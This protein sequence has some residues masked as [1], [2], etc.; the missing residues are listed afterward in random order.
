MQKLVKKYA[1][2]CER[3]KSVN[4]NLILLAT[5][6]GGISTNIVVAPWESQGLLYRIILFLVATASF[7]FFSAVILSMYSNICLNRFLS[8]ADN[9]N[10]AEKV[11]M[12]LRNFYSS[13]VVY[14]DFSQQLCGVGI[15]SS[16]V[17][18]FLH[19]CEI[20]IAIAFL[21]LVLFFI[22]SIYGK[23]Y[24]HKKSQKI[25]RHAQNR[26]MKIVEATI[27]EETTS[28]DFQQDKLE[29]KETKPGPS[30]KSKEPNS[31][32]ETFK[33]NNNQVNDKAVQ[34]KPTHS[35]ESILSAFNESNK[36][37]S[38]ESILAAFNSPSDS[39]P[40]G[41]NSIPNTNSSSNLQKPISK[42]MPQK[43]TATQK[44][45]IK[46]RWEILEK[47]SYE[48]SIDFSF[49]QARDIIKNRR[50]TIAISGRDAIIKVLMPCWKVLENLQ[51]P[52]LVKVYDLILHKEN[53]VIVMEEINKTLDNFMTIKEE[54]LANKFIL[55]VA[56][57]LYFLEE[58]DLFHH[59]FNPKY[60]SINDKM[61]PKIYWAGIPKA[62]VEHETKTAPDKKTIKLF[63]YLS[64]ES[65]QKNNHVTLTSNIYTLGV[66]WHQLLT[67]KNPYDREYLDKIFY[68]KIKNEIPSIREAS[69]DVSEQTERM[70]L[71]M[72]SKEPSNRP[73]S[74]Q[75]IVNFISRNLQHRH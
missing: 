59:C 5:F 25:Y 74:F 26:V 13:G 51:N 6:L 70:V 10:D 61:K 65:L 40:Q 21:S 72:M 64:L 37:H 47:L 45:L 66:I 55:E 32:L 1:T 2:T 49:Y 68:Q 28:K 73:Q 20:D 31:K 3:Y 8:G 7:A 63:S 39:Q 44:K 4:N 43:V 9:A 69:P 58:N 16:L 14:K 71:R 19:L 62:V 53:L 50:A 41:S 34:K 33:S 48:S 54:E 30:V 12:I 52:G 56:K 38:H 60:I 35:R 17:F 18:I 36:K 29:K 75:T 24:I 67:G 22:V 11:T 23:S 15:V 27:K 42:S 57:T 46:D